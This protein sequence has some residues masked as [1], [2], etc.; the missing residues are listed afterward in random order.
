MTATQ[1]T[2]RVI[3]SET[4]TFTPPDPESS[5]S[6]NRSEKRAKRSK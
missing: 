5:G 4:V 2:G 1:V 3:T 6:N